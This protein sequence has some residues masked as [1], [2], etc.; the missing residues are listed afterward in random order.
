LNP[1]IFLG[2]TNLIF[3]HNFF[4]S[5][6]CLDIGSQEVFFCIFFLF[7]LLDSQGVYSDVEKEE[8]KKE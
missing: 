2:P 6:E 3:Q 8:E 4:K 1:N 5:P 7:Q